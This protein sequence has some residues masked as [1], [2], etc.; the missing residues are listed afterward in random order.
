LIIAVLAGTVIVG[1]SRAMAQDKPTTPQPVTPQAENAQPEQADKPADPG[2]GQEAGA[3]TKTEKKEEPK[4]EE[5]KNYYYKSKAWGARIESEPPPYVKAVNKSKWLKEWFDGA[6]EINWLDFGIEQRT[7]WE[8]R[9]DDFRK[10]NLQRDNEFLLRSRLYLGIKEIMDPFR[11]AVEFQD[12]REFNSDFPEDNRD[13]DESDLLQAYGELFFEDALGDDR[14]LRFQFGRMAFDYIDRKLV[15]RNRW[16]NTT[17]SFDGFRLQLGQQSNDW[18]LDFLAVQPVVRTFRQFDNPNESQ[19]FYGVVGAWR[20]WS[21]HVSF[22][23]YYFFLDQDRDREIPER[24]IH[25]LGLHTF[26]PI[27]GTNFD[28]DTDLAYQWGHDGTLGHR[29]FFGS[30][31]LGYTFKHDWKPR[32]SLGGVYA[33]GDRDPTDDMAERFDRLF[34]AGHFYS[35]LDYFTLRNVISPT[36]RVE[37]QLHKKL[38]MDTAY[39]G[40]WLASDSDGWTETTRRDRTGRSGD[41]VGSE[42]DLR[43]RYQLTEF[44]ELEVGYSHFFQGSFVDNTGPSDDS[45]FFY[46]QTTVAIPQ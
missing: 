18:Q 12:S 45:D 11:I 42:I 40:Y 37:F 30:G 15:A 7:R 9:D 22:E 41:C 8:Y 16:R 44:A 46:V 2:P 21:Q 43:A 4:K 5:K 20:R 32:I 17:N 6:E 28:Y 29:A 38:R 26:G 31:E 34:G 27:A 25:T 36:L 23:P 14:P 24:N 35:D 1:G 10:P 13:V 19:F 3:P 39:R 33:S